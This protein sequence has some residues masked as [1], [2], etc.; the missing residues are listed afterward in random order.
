MDKKNFAFA[1]KMKELSQYSLVK[2]Q[3]RN[4]QS[5]YAIGKRYNH[6]I[7]HLFHSVFTLLEKA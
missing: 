2:L 1:S 4:K 3:F 6:V 7:L 5:Q